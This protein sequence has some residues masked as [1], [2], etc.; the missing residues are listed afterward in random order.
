MNR[1]VVLDIGNSAIHAAAVD[2]FSNSKNQIDPLSLSLNPTALLRDGVDKATR[3]FIEGLDE[4]I[5]W[6]AVSVNQSGLSR[7]TSCLAEIRPND[8][9]EQLVHLDSPIELRIDAP[10]K[11]GM[12]RVAAAVAA[13][14]MREPNKAA[15]IVDSGTAITVDVVDRAGRFLGGAIMPGVGVAAFALD[16]RTDALPRIIPL[17]SPPPS[18]GTNTEDAIRSGLF[19]GTFGGVKELVDRHRS[20]LDGEADLFLTGGAAVWSQLLEGATLVPGLTLAGVAQIADAKMA[21]EKSEL[22]DGP[23][24]DGDPS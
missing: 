22:G 8:R 19:W 18:I 10:D 14:S 2:A 16:E 12:D 20:R 5:T 11:V 23:G 1:F 21:A 24:Q 6:W 7:L 17:D 4:P 15:L 9:V 3:Q 13:N